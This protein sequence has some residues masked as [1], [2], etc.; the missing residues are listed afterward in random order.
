MSN[1]T[2]HLRTGVGRSPNPLDYITKKTACAAAPPGTPHP[3][4]DVFLERITDENPELQAFLQR[5]IGY[6]CTGFT[7]EHVFVF[8]Y[9]TGANG[10][11]YLHQHHYEHLRHLRDRRRHEHLPGYP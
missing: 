11:G 8:A 9:G 2:Y 6:C 10:K 3:L 1:A 7:H 4:W 5:Y